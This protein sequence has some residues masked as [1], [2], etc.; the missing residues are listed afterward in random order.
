MLSASINRHGGINISPFEKNNPSAEPSGQKQGAK[1]EVTDE[2]PSDISRCEALL[3]EIFHNSADI[4]IQVFHTGKDK[5]LLVN[6]DGM[7][8]KDLVDRDILAPLKS[9]DFDGRITCAITAHLK[10]VDQLSLAVQEVLNGNVAVFYENLNQAICVDFKHWQQRGVENPEAENVTRG[11]KEGYTENIRTN[12]SL[13]RRKIREPNLIIENYVFGRQTNTLVELA[14]VGGIVNR[15]VLQRVRDRMSEIDTDAILESG[16][17]EH[18]ISKNPLSPVTG[19]GMTQK[20]DIT[21]ARILEGRVAIFCDGSPHV[22]T[23]PEL[24]IENIQTSEDYYHGMLI[25][26]FMRLLRTLGLFIT[27]MLPAYAAAVMTYNQEMIPPVFLTTIITATEKTPLPASMEILL[28]IIMFELLNEAGVR[29]PKTVGSAITIVGSLII[30]DAA[31]SAGLVGAPTVII[32]ALTAVTG[33][34]VPNLHEFTV[35]YRFFFLFLGSSMGLIGIGAGNVMLAVQLISTESFG[36]PILSSF[37]GSEMKDSIIRF[38]MWLMKFRPRAI[39]K[40]NV[41]RQGRIR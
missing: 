27:T 28:M 22:L 32:V 2:V 16:F 1:P 33:F 40:D 14:Y 8:D 11:P 38:P 24:F 30:G 5:A 35:M 12:T 41:R 19:V 6:V 34:I 26:T 10:L 29:L 25:A 21:A 9:K 37:S 39:A 15:D 20:P 18:F 31:V 23:I 4:I 36:V 7:V 3:K 17:I 13:L